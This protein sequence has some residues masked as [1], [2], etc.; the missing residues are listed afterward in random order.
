MPRTLSQLKSRLA[1]AMAESDDAE[2]VLQLIRDAVRIYEF[3]ASDI[4]PGPPML[5]QINRDPPAAVERP[6]ANGGRRSAKKEPTAPYGDANGNTW[7]VKV[8]GQTG[9]WK[10]WPEAP[11]SSRF[12]PRSRRSPHHKNSLLAAGE[13]PNPS[14]HMPMRRAILG[15]AKGG[16]PT[17]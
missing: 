7:S 4:F 9:L 3:E 14:L 8:G 5:V 17:G 13:E 1:Q 10:S 16:D 11:Y 12:P 2:V 15:R 6:K